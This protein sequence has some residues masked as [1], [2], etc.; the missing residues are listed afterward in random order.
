[1]FSGLPLQTERVQSVS[2]LILGLEEPE[3]S[4]PLVSNHFAT[5]ETSDGNYHVDEGT[6][7][8]YFIFSFHHQFSS[9]N[10]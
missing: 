8:K 4:L 9:S 10:T 6:F 7:L 5:G 1:M 2:L 3:V